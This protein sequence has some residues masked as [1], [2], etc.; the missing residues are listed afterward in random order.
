[1]VG[2][3]GYLNATSSASSRSP[4]SCAAV[5]VGSA[6]G[7]TASGSAERR[8]VRAAWCA[9]GTKAEAEANESARTS[10]MVQC[11]NAMWTV[12]INGDCYRGGCQVAGSFTTVE[13]YF[14]LHLF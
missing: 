4:A 11:N 8:E 3:G 2:S 12:R 14:F 5:G 6:A 13:F 1:M 7:S 9:A 10:F